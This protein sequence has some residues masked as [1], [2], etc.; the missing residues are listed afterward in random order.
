LCCRNGSAG[1]GRLE[2]Q[3]RL[4]EYIEAGFED[5]GSG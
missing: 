1:K 5:V 4:G 2:D 3:V